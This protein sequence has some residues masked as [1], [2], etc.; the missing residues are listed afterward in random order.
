MAPNENATESNA[1]EVLLNPDCGIP[2]DIH[3]DIED[4]AGTT[5]GSFG[6]HKNIL[7]LKSPVFKA[8]LFG[9]LRETGDRI[10]IK[11][12]SMKA[13]KTMLLYVY[14]VDEEWFPWSLDM[15]DIF[16]TM[17]LALRYNFPGLQEK[18]LRHAETVF[19]E[20]ERLL[21]I[22]KTA[23]SFH[24][25]TE[26]SEAVLTT[27]SNFLLAI[28]E[29]PEHFNDFVSKWSGKSSEEADTVLRLLASIDHSKLAYANTSLQTN[30]VISHLRNISVVIK[31]RQRLQSL[32]DMIEAA[33]GV[34]KK[35]ILDTINDHDHEGEVYKHSLWVCQRLDEE[36]ASGEGIPLT[37]DTLVEDHF[38]HEASVKLHL[39]LIR[40]A[41]LD[42]QLW[43]EDLV[44]FLWKEMLKC[45]PEVKSIMF[46]WFSNN[47]QILENLG[48][49][50]LA[51]NLMS[52]DATLKE[53]PGYED[54]LRTYEDYDLALVERK[55]SVYLRECCRG[56]K[57]C[58]LGPQ[59]IST[60]FKQS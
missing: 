42:T 29:T 37:L 47:R 18:V 58:F 1:N 13:F 12:T 60:N 10:K 31:P 7:A 20:K 59:S 32:K 36:K 17:D 28:F 6:C 27:C 4:E 48:R 14:G 56:T 25:Y 11:A 46:H 57:H 9:S 44:S 39:D 33:E 34:S 5:L 24:I 51:K 16:L 2:F 30:K 41:L 54:A 55:M 52:C 21:E 35:N 15:R 45:I 43:D 19:I 53:L 38:T 50:L 40:M 22:A 23:E 8:M 3:F 49:Y 26:L